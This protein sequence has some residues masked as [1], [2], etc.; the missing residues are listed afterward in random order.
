VFL[1]LALFLFLFS[2]PLQFGKH[3]WISDSF[4]YGLRIDY[5][6]PTFYLQDILIFV[7]FLGFL[8]KNFRSLIIFLSSKK[9]WVFFYLLAVVF[10]I[11][12]SFRPWISFFSWLRAT[13][14]LFL[15]IIIYKKAERALSFLLRIL[16]LTIVLESFL[17]FVQVFKSFSV[18]GAF[19]FLG[20]RTFNILTPGIARFDLMGRVFL[21]PYGTFSHPNSLAGFILVS[22]VLVLGKRRLSFW[23]KFSVLLGAALIML[24]FSQAAWAA[25]FILGLGALVFGLARSFFKRSSYPFLFYFFLFLLPMLLFLFFLT[26]ASLDSFLIRRNLAVFSWKLFWNNFL[27]G[28]G[29]N[30]FIIKLS[31]GNFNWGW[32]FW[33][34]P[35][36]NIFLLAGSEVGLMGFLALIIFFILAIKRL[37]FYYFLQRE[38][39]Y[40]NLLLAIFIIIFTG[41]FDHYWFTL[42]QNQLLLTIILSLSYGLKSVKMSYE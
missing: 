26:P 37:L 13:E 28:V 23:D 17:G 42:V 31:E 39:F 3:F 21:R 35:V 10:N 5:L 11:R 33:L 32:L 27:I 34:Q 24:S 20:E 36:H 41:F 19:W 29:L 1:D 16:P 2:L 4:I 8:L 30:N 7:L 38:N 6:S 25:L 18:G 9:I 14:Y 15:G 40:I 22:I 12:F